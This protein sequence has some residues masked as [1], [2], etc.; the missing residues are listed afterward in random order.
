MSTDTQESKFIEE[1]DGI[2]V[3][4]DAPETSPEGQDVEDKPVEDDSTQTEDPDWDDLGIPEESR[5]T[6]D[7]KSA[8]ELAKMHYNLSKKLGEQSKEVSSARELKKKVDELESRLSKKREDMTREEIIAESSAEDLRNMYFKQKE[9]LESLDPGTD[10]YMEAQ[11]AL[12][13]LQ[14][15]YNAKLTE[16]N[17]QRSMTQ[18]DNAKFRKEQE[19]RFEEI[20]FELSDDQLE[21]LHDLAI[22][23]AEIRNNG[24]L[25][26]AAYDHAMMEAVGPEYFTKFWELRGER[27]AV[28]KQKAAKGKENITARAEGVGKGE[29]R[30]ASITELDSYLDGLSDEELD[31]YIAR[32]A[33]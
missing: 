4:D 25:N 24:R 28:E 15:D 12:D 32:R 11:R 8:Q 30:R 3:T 5:E 13:N 2:Y 26:E 19:Q 33:S 6:Y 9:V 22:Q 17:V 29:K 16:E 20:G 7:G 21:A 1:E 23:E 27:N 14:L 10:E 18:E 31:D